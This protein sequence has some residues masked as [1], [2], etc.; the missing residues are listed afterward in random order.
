MRRAPDVLVRIAARLSWAPAAASARARGAASVSRPAFS[1]A[2]ARAL[3][4]E[5]DAQ[6]AAAERE[7]RGLLAV[8]DALLAGKD[9]MLAGKDAQL[10]AADRELHGLLSSRDA[11][12]AAADREL[13]GLLSSRDAQLAAA[14][15]ELQGLLESRDAL[16]REKDARLSD[17]LVSHARELAIAMHAADLARGVLNVRGLF[18][19]CVADVWRESGGLPDDRGSVSDKLRQLLAA[20]PARCPGLVAYMKVAAA[21]NGVPEQDLLRQ[22]GRLYEVLSERLHSDA[23]SGAGTTRLP[24]A[25][26]ERSG[27]ATMLA[28]AAFVR[29]T[30]RNLALYGSDGK[31][32]RLRLRAIEPLSSPCE[33]TQEQLRRL[34]AEDV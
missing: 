31:A 19:A 6:L 20:G 34:P 3:L 18:E 32:Q 12:L 25:V 23:A 27:R 28:L 7:L 13:H 14:D 10:A 33:I 11:Q 16:L 21:D 4:A 17:R 8:K 15:R 24:A 26:F 2:A 29:F 9:A 30:G 1:A 5:K 22:A